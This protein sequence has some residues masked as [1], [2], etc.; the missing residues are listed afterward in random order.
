MVDVLWAHSTP[1]HGT[2]HIRAR[3]GPADIGI[4]L[5]IRAASAD[6]A[7]AK[8]VRLMTDALA[9]GAVGDRGY[10]VTLHS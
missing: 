5:F 9:S 2:E 10:S 8:A 4:I 1:G 6:I 3:T 7:Q